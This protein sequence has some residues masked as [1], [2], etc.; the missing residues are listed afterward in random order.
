MRETARSGKTPGKKGFS[1]TRTRTRGLLTLPVPAPW[2]AGTGAGTG[3]PADRVPVHDS[4]P[5][6]KSYA[7]V[8]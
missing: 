4:G 6:W 7:T 3:K 8:Y 1:L 5:P 2:S